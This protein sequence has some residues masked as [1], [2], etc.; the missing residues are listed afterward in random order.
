[1]P[2]LQGIATVDLQQRFSEFL[3]THFA[4]ESTA[5]M[6]TTLLIA[7]GTMADFL[8]ISKE[9]FLK[10]CGQAADQLWADIEAEAAAASGGGEE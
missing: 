10:G 7:A 1:M 5:A 2:K 4:E 6:M 8:G 3:N 9:S